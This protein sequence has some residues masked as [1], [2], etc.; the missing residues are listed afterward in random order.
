[1]TERGAY[2][3]ILT[4]LRKVKAPHVHLEDFNYFINKGIQEFINEEYTRF[5]TVQQTSD[6]LN[7]I[8]SYVNYKF[9]YTNPLSPSVTITGN[10]VIN[11]TS[12]F[13]VGS[14]FNSR[15]V[16]VNFPTNYLHLLNCVADVKANFNYKCYPAGYIH[17]I[18]A[19]KYNADSAS[20]AMANAWTKPSFSRPFYKLLDHAST[21]SL[22]QADNTVLSPDIQIYFGDDKKFDVDNIYTEYLRKPKVVNLTK[23]QIDLPVDT[24]AQLDFTDYVCNEIIKRV[25]KLLFENSKDQQRLQTFIPVN[26]TVK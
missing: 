26:A 13:L 4:E 18:G 15:Y 14:R 3:A 22:T 19:K 1:M 11:S 16:Q 7:S 6:A 2:E 23:P 21:G 20:S 5:E 8:T 25:V 17:S 24:S 9:N 12:S 10:S